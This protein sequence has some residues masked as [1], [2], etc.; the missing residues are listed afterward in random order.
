MWNPNC[1]AP[2]RTSLKTR[3]SFLYSNVCWCAIRKRKFYKT[4]SVCIQLWFYCIYIFGMPGP[5]L[6]N[7]WRFSESSWRK[8]QIELKKS[9]MP[10][11]RL[12]G[13]NDSQKIEKNHQIVLDVQ[14]ISQN[15]KLFFQIFKFSCNVLRRSLSNYSRVFICRSFYIICSIDRESHNSTK[16]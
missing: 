4:F 11:N 15:V 5:Q 8:R 1:L 16:M 9:V 14:P 3:E 12:H 10:S 6:V 7:L 13:R 2:L